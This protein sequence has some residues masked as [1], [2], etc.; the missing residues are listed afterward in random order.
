MN[1]R[2]NVGWMVMKRDEE[3]REEEG[4]LAG[5]DGVLW[6]TRSCVDAG[7]AKLRPG[8]VLGGDGAPSLADASG[9]P[10]HI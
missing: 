2:S 4:Q 3:E 1:A 7:P 10:D 9:I 6:E 5:G 8:D